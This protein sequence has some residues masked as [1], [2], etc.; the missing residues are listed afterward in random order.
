[1]GPFGKER[2]LGESLFM[3]RESFLRRFAPKGVYKGGKRGFETLRRVLEALCCLRLKAPGKR[4]LIEGFR[5]KK[6]GGK[7]R[8][9]YKI[10]FGLEKF[11]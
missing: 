2:L 1:M 8:N 11:F 10:Y 9:Y 7:D 5:L 6:R 3:W 4:A